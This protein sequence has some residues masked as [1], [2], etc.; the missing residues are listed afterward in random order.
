MIGFLHSAS[1]HLLIEVYI[2]DLVVIWIVK[3][4]LNF[5]MKTIKFA[6]AKVHVQLVLWRFNWRMTE[7]QLDVIG[8]LGLHSEG[9]GGSGFP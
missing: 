3:L 2:M 4:C 1:Q 9:Y 8:G 7:I 5:A 6:L